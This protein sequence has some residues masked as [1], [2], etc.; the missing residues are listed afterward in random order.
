MIVINDFIL[1]GEG[2]VIAVE[3]DHHQ[4]VGLAFAGFGTEGSDEVENHGFHKFEFLFFFLSEI[5]SYMSTGVGE[6]MVGA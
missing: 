3:G 4:V 1:R 2:D 6:G 5:T